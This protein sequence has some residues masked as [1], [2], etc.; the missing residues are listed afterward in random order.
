MLCPHRPVKRGVGI[1]EVSKNDCKSASYF[2]VISSSPPPQ[3]FN[4]TGLNGLASAASAMMHWAEDWDELLEEVSARRVS[5]NTG[6]CSVIALSA[7]SVGPGSGPL[8]SP[9][10]QYTLL[11]A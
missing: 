2:L 9:I 6:V 8:R 7:Y 11:L 10:Y 1:V 4:V 5:L 3:N